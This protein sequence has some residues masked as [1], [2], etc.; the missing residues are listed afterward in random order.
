MNQPN[1]ASAEISNTYLLSILRQR[2]FLKSPIL[3]PHEYGYYHNPEVTCLVD[4]TEILFVVPSAP[5]NFYRR[6]LVRESPLNNWVKGYRSDLNIQRHADDIE[7][8]PIRASLLFFVAFPR[9]V[10]TATHDV[11]KLVNA[12][13]RQNRDIVQSDFIDIYHNV[14]LKHVMMLKWAATYCS[15][16][17]YVIRVD[18]DALVDPDQIVRTIYKIGRNH[19]NFVL[20]NIKTGY[21]VY[22]GA[23]EDPNKSKYAVSYGE[24]SGS[25]WPPFALGGL[26]GYPVVT[27]RLLYEASLRVKAVWLDDVYITGICA[28]AVNVT[29]LDHPR[30]TFKHTFPD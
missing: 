27:V 11:Q 26:L 14:R 8:K 5:D 1:S 13:A 2:Q 25:K 23:E 24:Y 3:N 19:N 22:R 4:K 15:N 7:D 17:T 12:E 9:F 30:F 10:G 18:D 6:K 16:A 21:D 20:G 28:R 29:L